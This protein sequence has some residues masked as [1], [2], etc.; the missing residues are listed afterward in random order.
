MDLYSGLNA[1]SAIAQI[2]LVPVVLWFGAGLVGAVALITL[3]NFASAAANWVLS[4][5]L[6]SAMG[7]PRVD[8]TLVAPLLKFGYPLVL[9]FLAE[10]VL[11]N[12]EKLFLSRFA[13]IRALA[14][15]SVAS[16]FAGLLAAVPNVLGQSLLPAF[17]TVHAQPDLKRLQVF[18]GRALRGMLF[19]MVPA[20]FVLWAIA[21]PF[22]SAW[23]GAEY[24]SYG[25]V[26]CYVLVVGVAVSVMGYIP[27]RLLMAA[28]QTATV[29]QYNYAELAPYLVVAALLTVKF[30]AIGAAAAWSLRAAVHAGLLFLAAARV[31]G[32]TPSLMPSHPVD[33]ALSA[34]LLFLAVVFTWA[35]VAPLWV[36]MLVL[37][38]SLGGYA[39]VL[40]VR[41]VEPDE[42]L[43][44]RRLISRSA[45]DNGSVAAGAN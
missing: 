13:S 2:C 18:Y 22:L 44:F 5:R 45:L 21:K 31:T 33:F 25:S 35:G 29:A 17:V 15:Y 27:Q 43:W 37:L 41:V 12:S 23:A 28:Q 7:T 20:V 39:S 6:L 40:W 8:R 16:S 36:S 10:I 11:V 38:V 4:K 34:V 26:P 3:I 9:C 1:A 32:P 24:G 30:G 42:R 19:S 14:Y